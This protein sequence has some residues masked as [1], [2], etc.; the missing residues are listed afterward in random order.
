MNEQDIIQE[1]IGV[2]ES[3]YPGYN[4]QTIGGDGE[5][6]LPAITVDWSTSRRTDYQ[7]NSPVAGFNRNSEGEV[8]EIVLQRYYQMELDIT[9][10]SHDEGERDVTLSN[11]QDTFLPFEWESDRFHADTFEWEVGDIR[12]RNNPYIEPDWY[13]AGVIVSFRF[14]DE[15]VEEVDALTSV[16]ED[17]NVTNQ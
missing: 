13:Q 10:K 8:V 14:V 12:P 4:V 5:V 11:I 1:V 9:V 2:L 17:V 6:T 7:G 15:V 3:N 16:Q